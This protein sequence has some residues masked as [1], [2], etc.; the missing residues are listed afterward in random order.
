MMGSTLQTLPY[1]CD[2]C[3]FSSRELD[4]DPGITKAVLAVAMT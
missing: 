4:A 3:G 2:G 1:T